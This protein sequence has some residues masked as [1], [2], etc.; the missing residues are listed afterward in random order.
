MM[1]FQISLLLGYLYA[2]ALIRYVGSKMQP[3]V[4]I[5]L[6]A[7]SLV[8]L[9]VYPSASW[10]PGGET[11]PTLGIVLLLAATIGLPYFLLSS[12]GPLLQAWY[13][14]KS[15]AIPYRLFA[16]SNFASLLALV[17]FPVAVEPF[18]TTHAQAN[19]WSG[20]YCIFALLCGASAWITRRSPQPE[21]PVCDEVLPA[22]RPSVVLKVLWVA[23]AAC[24]SPCCSG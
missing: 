2:H 7:I 10:K 4:H 24:A 8:L 22:T 1:Y 19:V 3:V 13:L 9:P 18:L 15:G 6:L 11:D 23:L 21:Q 14:R 20:V 17:T 16:L 5:G 12:T